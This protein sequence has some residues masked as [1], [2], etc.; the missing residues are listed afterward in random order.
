[1][2]EK[3][4]LFITVEGVEGAGKSTQ[5]SFIESY[6]LA[7]G[8]SLEVTRE[9]GGTPLAEEIRELLLRPRDNGMSPG[10]ELLLM[11]AARA[12]HLQNKIL[13]ALERGDWV[14]CDRFTDATYAYQGGGRQ[15][16]KSLIEELERLIQ[17]DH[18][19][20]IT[21]YL[22]LPVATG[23]E[24]ARKRG[25]LDRFEREGLDFF[26]RVRQAYL[27]RSRH[28]PDTYRVI[29]ASQSIEA[30]NSEIKTVLDSILLAHI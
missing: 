23:M 7:A 16:D 4:G 13:P 11:F 19:P 8:I 2:K 9:P 10:T 28:L 25:E 18:R 6:L 22:D 17:G 26:E 21:I 12:E 29:D 27:E 20:D 1:V 5:L 30:V 3:R 24:R 15:L 14:L